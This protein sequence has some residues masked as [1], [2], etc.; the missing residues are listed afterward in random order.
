[1]KKVPFA[2]NSIYPSPLSLLY[3]PQELAHPVVAPPPVHQEEP[4]QEAELR[5]A[6]VG[7]QHRLHALLAGDAHAD[8]GGCDGREKKES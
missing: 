3:S 5:D 8:V 2:S 1:M 6:V 4:L 7:G